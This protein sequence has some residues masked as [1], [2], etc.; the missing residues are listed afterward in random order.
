[1]TDGHWYHICGEGHWEH[2]HWEHA[3]EFKYLVKDLRFPMPRKQVLMGMI[4]VI[5]GRSWE[6]GSPSY[7]YSHD[8]SDYED[9]HMINMMLR[10]PRVSKKRLVREGGAIGIRLKEYITPTRECV[11]SLS[12]I[13]WLTAVII[14][15]I[16]EY[17]GCPLNRN[18]I[19]SIIRKPIK[20]QQ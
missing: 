16:L 4:R 8:D 6:D 1:M 3:F 10:D 14:V 13:R 17:V 12:R 18:E 7:S 19:L 9:Y 15:E 2:G 20:E 5:V 11:K